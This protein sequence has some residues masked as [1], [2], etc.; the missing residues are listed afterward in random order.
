MINALRIIMVYRRTMSVPCLRAEITRHQRKPR[1]VYLDQVQ[2][3]FAYRVKEFELYL[4][5][6]G[7]LLKCFKQVN[8]VIRFIL[9]F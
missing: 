7:K 3:S 1:K 4:V 5:G 8:D 6:V 2:D 9:V